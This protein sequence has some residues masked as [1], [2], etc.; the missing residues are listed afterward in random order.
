[1]AILFATV[2]PGTATRVSMP[3]AF[4][5]LLRTGIGSAEGVILSGIGFNLQANVQYLQ[6]LSDRVYVYS[7]GHAPG[8]AILSGVATTRLC[9]GE[10]AGRGASFRAAVDWYKSRSV[11]TNRNRTTFVVA[12]V[13]ISG[14]IDKLST[15]FASAESGLIGFDI[16]MTVIER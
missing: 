1:M 15:R 3:S 7:Y 5:A 14:F 10:I 6:T 16:Y 12:S 4:P 9:T 8:Q 11:A 2:A 13:E